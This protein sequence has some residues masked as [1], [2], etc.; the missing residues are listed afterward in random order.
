VAK[1]I[2]NTAANIKLLKNQTKQLREQIVVLEKLKKLE[3]GITEAQESQLEN[4][5]KQ[6][7]AKRSEL[8]ASKKHVSSSK[9]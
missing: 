4:Y 2:D 3:D 8:K 6:L 9:D 5:V 7:K 1:Q